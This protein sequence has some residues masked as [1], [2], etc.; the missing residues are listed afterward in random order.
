MN[1]DTIYI[2][3]FKEDLMKFSF[4]I[5]FQMGQNV[6]CSNCALYLLLLSNVGSLGIAGISLLPL[7]PNDHIP[8]ALGAWLSVLGLVF[9]VSLFALLNHV[10]LQTKLGQRCRKK[11]QLTIGEV[12]DI[13]N[14]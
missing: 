10:G 4:L 12:L 5:V 3:H 8:I 13:S 11:Y 6:K 14:K 9:F 1:K 7:H 2:F